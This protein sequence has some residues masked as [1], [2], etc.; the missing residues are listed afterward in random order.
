VDGA[1]SRR[2]DPGAAIGGT[3]AEFAAALREGRRPQSDARDNLRT[4]AMA[5]AVS[6][7][8]LE[9][10]GVDVE[11]DYFPGEATPGGG[12]GRHEA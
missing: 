7:S 1:D 12:M 3:L 9:G 6:R 11:R 10:R 5:F 8:S 2:T 4:L